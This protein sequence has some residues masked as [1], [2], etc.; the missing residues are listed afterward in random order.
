MH[1]AIQIEQTE[2]EEALTKAWALLHGINLVKFHWVTT[3]DGEIQAACVAEILT[4]RPQPIAPPVQTDEDLVQQIVGTVLKTLN[5]ATPVGVPVQ[6]LVP[7]PILPAALTTNAPA[8]NTVVE[9]VPPTTTKPVDPNTP[10]TNEGHPV[11][12]IDHPTSS[13][14]HPADVSDPEKIAAR[15]STLSKLQRIRRE[16]GGLTGTETH[17]E[18]FDP[19]NPPPG[20]DTEKH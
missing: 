17:V 5:N 12:W 7:A 15:Q 3:E 2:I 19:R 9:V 6:S 1:I 14:I 13:P 10:K 16:S 8:P 20:A 11:S 18:R 4:E